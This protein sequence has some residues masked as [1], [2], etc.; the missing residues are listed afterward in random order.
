[1]TEPS[2]MAASIPLI[3]GGLSVAVRRLC[4]LSDAELAAHDIAALNLLVARGLPG[5]EDL[6]VGA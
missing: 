4:S 1:M 6:D 3:Q 2:S 5:T